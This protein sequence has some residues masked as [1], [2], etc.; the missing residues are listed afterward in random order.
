MDGIAVTN[1]LAYLTIVIITAVKVFTVQA[2]G[3]VSLRKIGILYEI[4]I[5]Y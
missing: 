5:N 2:H 1:L 4:Y 3:G